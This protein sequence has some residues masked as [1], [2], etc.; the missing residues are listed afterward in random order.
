MTPNTECHY[1]ECHSQAFY[2]EC[3]YSEC[4]S[5]DICTTQN[6]LLLDIFKPG[7][8]PIKKYWSKSTLSL[9]KL[10][11]SKAMKIYSS[12]LKWSNFFQKD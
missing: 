9:C 10:G 8:N 1:S 2:A 6:V 3:R 4:R 7:A 12:I 5:A 11:H